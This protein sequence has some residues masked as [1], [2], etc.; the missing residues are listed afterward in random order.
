MRL[1]TKTSKNK[2]THEKT[3]FRNKQPSNYLLSD[4]ATPL[5]DQTT[6]DAGLPTC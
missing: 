5:L 3:D 4:A 2:P 6:V 1:F